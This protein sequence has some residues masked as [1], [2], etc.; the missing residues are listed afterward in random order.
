MKYENLEEAALMSDINLKDFFDNANISL[1]DRALYKKANTVPSYVA[2]MLFAYI[3]K[4]FNKRKHP[5]YYQRKEEFF[6]KMQESGYEIKNDKV[7]MTLNGGND[8]EI[9]AFESQFVEIAL[10]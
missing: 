4:E 7:I 3:S 2:T 1:K 8:V 9:N 5:D 6:K 10:N